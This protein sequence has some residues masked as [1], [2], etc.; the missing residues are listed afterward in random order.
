MKLPSIGKIE[1]FNGL[2]SLVTCPDRSKSNKSVK[3]FSKEEVRTKFYACWGVYPQ[4][5]EF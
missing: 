5:V 4:K 1:F 3:F 2:Q